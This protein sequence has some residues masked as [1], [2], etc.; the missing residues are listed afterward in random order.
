MRPREIIFLSPIKA[1]DRPIV[2]PFRYLERQ[3]LV[4]VTY[5]EFRLLGQLSMIVR[6][7]ERSP[8]SRVFKNLARVLALFV[9]RDRILLLGTEPF[10]LL[11][12]WVNWLKARHRCL[13]HTSWAWSEETLADRTWIP[14]RR[15]IWQSFLRDTVSVSFT[16]NGC[17]GL[18]RYGA[19]AF[20]VP[21]NVDTDVFHPAPDPS[22]QAGTTIVLFAGN[23]ERTK[24][25]DVII[26]VIRS[27]PWDG[28]TFW[29]AGRGRFEDE[30]RQLARDGYPVKYVGFVRDRQQLADLYRSAD[31]LI[32]PSV[33]LGREEERFGMVLIEA[34][35]CGLPVIAT[36][37]VG[38]RQIIAEG[39]DGFLIPQHDGHALREAILRLASDP[40]LR[41][42]MGR[43]G[44]K[45]AVEEYDVR[46][47]ARQWMDVIERA[48]DPRLSIGGAAAE[49][50]FVN[51]EP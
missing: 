23:L 16:R 48:A 26:D 31:M 25:V 12:L 4:T 2:D 29:F 44:R 20:Y 39:Q 37:C 8:V 7:Q 13:Y 5:V 42:D 17:E 33:Q 45:K 51:P 32:L 24:G 46:I 50:S 38:P 34:M 43:R 21:H 6:G 10:R 35:A 49:P 27:H 40:G 18:T 22:R 30:I 11:S 47:V 36:D 14:F 28:Q 3:G 9:Q 15:R 1:E 19:R 41:A